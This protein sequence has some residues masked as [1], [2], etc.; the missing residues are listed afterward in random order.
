MAGQAYPRCL[1]DSIGSPQA[2]MEVVKKSELQPN[3]PLSLPDVH[4][5]AFGRGAGGEGAHTL[6]FPIIRPLV[7]AHK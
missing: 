1:S 5:I 6:L 7:Y 3:T 2:L 4:G